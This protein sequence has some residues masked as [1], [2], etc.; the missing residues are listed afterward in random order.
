MGWLFDL[1][2]PGSIGKDYNSQATEGYGANV[3]CRRCVSAIAM[4]GAGIEWNLYQRKGK[5][6]REIEEHAILDLLAQPNPGMGGQRFIEEVLA[7]LMLNGN[8]YLL[9]V[10]PDGDR[11]PLELYALRPDRMRPVINSDQTEIESW[12]YTVG[13]AGKDIPAKQLC[14]LKLFNPLDDVLGLSP[15]QTAALSIQTSNAAKTWNLALLENGAR[16]MGA[17]STK[18]YLQSDQIN[19]LRDQFNGKYAG[20]ENAGRPIILEGEMSWQEMGLSPADMSWLESQ[21][22]T[23]REIAICY[24]VP[25]EMI[26]DASNKTYSNY[27]EA[28]KA[29]YTE[30]ILPLMDWLEGE[31]NRWLI[32]KYGKAT[33]LQLRYDRDDIDALQEDRTELWGR[34]ERASWLTLNEKREACGYEPVQGGDIILIPA[35]ML[36]A[37]AEVQPTEPQR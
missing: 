7:Y 9:P 30:T 31:L 20:V 29:F 18:S 16:P 35:T 24:G 10:G 25:P 17:L 5:E 33:G 3:Y 13:T 32:P 28:R 14:H 15:I 4:A 8:S 19:N 34:L 11:P 6:L 12:R 21:K 1:R 2:R 37:E 36:P 23:A 22:L 26:G 27:R